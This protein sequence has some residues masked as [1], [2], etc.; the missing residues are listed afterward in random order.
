MKQKPTFLIREF[1]K[2]KKNFNRIGREKYKNIL[3]QENPELFFETIQGGKPIQVGK[4]TDFAFIIK[5]DSL[6]CAEHSKDEYYFSTLHFL[7]IWKSTCMIAKKL[8][9][10]FS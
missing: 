6:K 1:P 4:E 8:I 2:A 5:N 9:D 10:G 3:Q 7:Q